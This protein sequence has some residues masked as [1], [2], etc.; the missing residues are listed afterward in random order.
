LL[1]KTGRD[2]VREMT[3]L[4][5]VGGA[6][7]VTGVVVIAPAASPALAGLAW[8]L[9]AGYVFTSDPAPEA[10]VPVIEGL[11]ERS[12]QPCR[13]TAEHGIPTGRSAVEEDITTSPLDL[14]D[15]V[16]S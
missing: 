16:D 11:M 2:L 8:H 4:E 13:G 14:E 6:C 5:R 10:L 3:L 9:G 15:D 12:C 1:V 7:P